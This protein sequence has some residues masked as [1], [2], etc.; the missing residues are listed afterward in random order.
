MQFAVKL[1]F[2]PISAI[3]FPFV[4]KIDPLNFSAKIMISSD[5][6]K[7]EF[8]IGTWLMVLVLGLKNV[9]DEM[10]IQTLAVVKMAG[11]DWLLV[12]P[13]TTNQTAPHA[14]LAT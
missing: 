8:S 11:S 2:S 14:A 10:M 5:F 3:S 6:A 9:S 1:T 4:R 13:Q 7:L 12:P